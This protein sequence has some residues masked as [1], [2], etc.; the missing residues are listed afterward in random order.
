MICIVNIHISD[1]LLYSLRPRTACR[2]DR[3][4]FGRCE[5][6]QKPILKERK[7]GSIKSGNVVS[8]AENA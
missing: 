1:G 7:T 8:V 6:T 2:L 3:G 4:F 5:T